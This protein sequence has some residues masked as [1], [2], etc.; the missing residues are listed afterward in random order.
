[1]K[2]LKKISRKAAKQINGGAGPIR[3]SATKPCFI[4]SCCRGVCME[5]I[6]MEE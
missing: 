6:C 5:Y 1:M 3:C 4:G 2:N